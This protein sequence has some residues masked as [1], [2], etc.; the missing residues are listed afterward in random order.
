MRVNAEFKARLRA[1]LGPV[2]GISLIAYLSYHAV[3]G[4][5][6]LIAHR[7]I[8][9]QLVAAQIR[10]KTLLRQR[11]VLE[12]RVKLLHPGSLDRDILE[13]QARFILGYSY[14]DEQVFFRR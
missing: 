14:P 10:H 12:H 6:G 1:I 7:Q 11:I 2:C 3:Q 5:R 8:T 4:D 9:Q 13:E